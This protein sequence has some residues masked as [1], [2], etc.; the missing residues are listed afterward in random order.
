[1][2]RLQKILSAA[3]VTSRRKAEE[4]MLEGRVTVNGQVVREL[5]TKADPEQD[6][7]K[8][9]GR[10]IGR[11]P[12]KVYLLLNKPKGVVSTVSDPER[13]PVVTDLVRGAGRLYPV[14]RLDYNTEGLILLTNDGEFAR[15]VS[16]A[17]AD[18]P[19][20]YHAKVKGRVEEAELER[21]RSGIRATDGT[22]FAPA[23]IRP[24]RGGNNSWYEVTLTEG[25]NH[26]VRR[27]FDAVG[28]TVLKLRR[29]G[30]GFLTDRGL[31]V[32]A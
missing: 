16:R 12:E 14:G 1:M 10:R 25:K 15:I 24:L 27:M 22:R 31:A 26:E 7:I 21:L 8:V 9:D 30:I 5:G 32:G 18:V 23:R 28:H 11:F 13:R 2:E 3:G 29:V 17:G 4:L 19:R 6:H 20:I